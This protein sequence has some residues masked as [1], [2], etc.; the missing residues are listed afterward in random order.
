MLNY[1]NDREGALLSFCRI[2]AP[3]PPM[4]PHDSKILYYLND[5]DEGRYYFCRILAPPSPIP[6]LPLTPQYLPILMTERGRA[7]SFVGFWRP[8][9]MNPP[10]PSHDAPILKYILMTE[11]RDAIIFVGFWGWGDNIL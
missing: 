2:L 5:R 4:P 8:P 11:M 1:L 7:L 9:P 10:P 3:P 6:P